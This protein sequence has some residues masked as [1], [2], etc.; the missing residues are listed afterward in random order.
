[1]QGSVLGGK[2]RRVGTSVAATADAAG[3][4]SFLTTPPR[5]S[6][7]RSGTRQLGGTRPRKQVGDHYGRSVV[8]PSASRPVHV[9]ERV[10]GGAH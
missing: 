5:G 7:S 10:R 6:C 1:M 3:T 8:A 9:S 4:P 2:S